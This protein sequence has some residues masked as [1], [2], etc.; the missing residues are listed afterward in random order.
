M[1]DEVI[2]CFLL[3]P[4]EQ[5]RVN[6][7]RYNSKGPSCLGN[8]RRRCQSSSPFKV[9]PNTKFLTRDEYPEVDMH[10]PQLCATC[11]HPFREE[12]DQKQIS[13][14][15]IYR[16]EGT[17]IELTRS[18]APAGAMWNADWLDNIRAAGPDGK[19]IYVRLPD[20]IDWYVDGESRQDSTKPGWNRTGV[21]PNIT[22]TPNVKTSSWEGS[23]T[24][25]KLVPKKS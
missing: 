6:L 1:N 22:V 13:H 17:E 21:V 8:P 23:L 2:E 19:R 15:L 9:I 10:W 14:E 25:G 24:N 4:T 18:D 12:D 11:G 3:V 20:G 7:R 5:Y 16:W